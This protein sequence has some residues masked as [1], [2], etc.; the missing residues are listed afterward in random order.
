MR[1]QT[2][3]RP[4]SW[5]SSDDLCR[6]VAAHDSGNQMVKSERRPARSRTSLLIRGFH[7][8]FIRPGEA[9][10]NKCAVSCE[11]VT[12]APSGCGTW[13]VKPASRSSR[14]T[15]RSSRSPFTTWRSTRPNATSPAPGRTLS[16]RC[17]YDVELHVPAPPPSHASR[18]VSRDQGPIET[19]HGTNRQAGA[20][21]HFSQ[22]TGL[23]SDLQTL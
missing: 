3:E 19:E 9:T 1:K 7:L 8:M 22:P 18:S 21:S 6:N 16:Q 12:T 2:A 4:V 14:L 15:G 17:S 20:Q 13:R 11:Q 10:V 5:V 23:L